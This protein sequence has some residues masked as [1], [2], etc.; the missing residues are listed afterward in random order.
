M[1]KTAHFV[2][3]HNFDIY[4]LNFIILLHNYFRRRLG[5]VMLGVCVYVC[6]S[7]ES[8]LPAALA[9]AAMVMRCIQWSPVVTVVAVTSLSCSEYGEAAA[10]KRRGIQTNSDNFEIL[11][12][13]LWIRQN[14]AEVFLPILDTTE[15]NA[16]MWAGEDIIQSLKV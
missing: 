9:S 4:Q 10:T 8:R 14:G 3:A 1:A 11:P 5:I 12:V 13:L 16:T 7:A 2:S 6:V 15:V